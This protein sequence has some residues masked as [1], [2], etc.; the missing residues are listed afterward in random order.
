MGLATSG[1][2]LRFSG[3]VWYTAYGSDTQILS[4]RAG[5]LLSTVFG[6]KIY[7]PARASRDRLK[8]SS[9][10]EAMLADAPIP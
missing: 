10:F 2:G 5:I 6:A 3:Q 9:I 4:K 1:S 8:P 7:L